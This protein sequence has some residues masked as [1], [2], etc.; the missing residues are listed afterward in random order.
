MDSK[1]NLT[2]KTFRQTRRMRMAGFAILL[3]CAIAA[4]VFGASALFAPNEKFIT[5]AA[6]DEAK[7]A[8]QTAVNNSLDSNGSEYTVTLGAEWGAVKSDNDSSFGTG[9]GF[10]S[11]GLYVPAGA[12]IVL[13][14][15]GYT[16]GRNLNV[17]TYKEPRTNGYVINVAGT[18]TIKDSSATGLG[19]IRDGGNTDSYSAGGV[20]VASTGVFNMQG[21]TIT[22]NNASKTNSAGGVYVA[23]GGKFHM[24]GGVISG[25]TAS[26]LNQT[27]GTDSTGGVYCAG[28]FTATGGSITGNAAGVGGIRI[29]GGTA[30]LSGLT[31]SANRSDASNY[32][33]KSGGGLYVSAEAQVTLENVK[34]TGNTTR[35]GHSGIY[36]AA[37][38]ELTV[39]NCEISGNQTDSILESIGALCVE[40]AA[41]VS[42]TR[43]FNNSAAIS[44][45]RVGGTLTL[46]DCE[47][48]GNSASSSNKNASQGL[49]TTTLA[50]SNLTLNN[51]VVSGNTTL[52]GSTFALNKGKLILN[53][54]EVKE[55]ITNY[56][57]YVPAAG[58]LS[59]GGKTYIYDNK[60]SADDTAAQ[61][62][63]YFVSS[64][65]KLGVVSALTTESK[66]GIYFNST[67]VL[68][69]G[70]GDY[71]PGDLSSV[72]VNE[73]SIA[74]DFEIRTIQFTEENGNKYDRREVFAQSHDS[75]SN[76]IYAVKQSL[77]NNT[78]ETCTLYSN[79]LTTS[80][81]FGSDATAFI[82]GSL[83]AP[84]GASVILD[85]NGFTIGYSKSST[86]NDCVI[87]VD[88]TLVIRDTSAAQTGKISG[89]YSYETSAALTGGVF[90]N[91]S[92]S[93]TLEG[94]TITGNKSMVKSTRGAGNV[95]VLGHFTMT[96]GVISGGIQQAYSGGVAYR[97][98]GAGGVLVAGGAVFEATGGTITG[99]VGSCID[100]AGGI[101]VERGGTCNLSGVTISN[102]TADSLNSGGA[103]VSYGALTITNCIISGNSEDN[104]SVSTDIAG[105]L[106]LYGGTAN[107]RDTQFTG[108]ASRVNTAA[109]RSRITAT[110]TN[111]T[112][113]GNYTNVATNNKNGKPAIWNTGNL[114]LLNCEIAGN[115]TNGTAKTFAPLY[116][117]AGA[118]VLENTN[119]K[120][121]TSYI[122]AVQIAGGTFTM[123][124]G[125]ISGNKS[126]DPVGI[127]YIAANLTAEFED[128]RIL[129]NTGTTVNGLQTAA[130]SNVTLTDCSITGGVLT[131]TGV[132]Y[133]VG[134]I[135]GTLTLENCELKNNG[136]GMYG[137]YVAA[138]GKLNIGGHTY[139]Y[140]NTNT[141]GEQKNVHIVSRSATIGVLSKLEGESK[142][143]VTKDATGPLTSGF[144][145]F[146]PGAEPEKYFFSDTYTASEITSVLVPDSEGIERVEA[147]TASHNPV[148]NWETAVQSSLDN[149]GATYTC[150]LY[151]DWVAPNSGRHNFGTTSPYYN[152]GALW[153]PA[154]AS[155]ILDLNGHAV[156]RTMGNSAQT[157]G[158]VIYVQGTLEIQ[159]NSES[160]GGKVKGGSNANNSWHAGGIHID[161]NG[162]L[163]LTSGSISENYNIAYQTGSAGV[164]VSNNAVFE[165]RGGSISNNTSIIYTSGHHG[166]GAVR[167]AAGGTF[168]MTGGTISNNSDRTSAAGQGG[169]IMVESGATANISNA[170]V[171]NNTAAGSGGS[172]AITS[173]GT[174]TIRDSVISGNQM[175]NQYAASLYL[176]GTAEIYDTEISGNRNTAGYGAIF[177]VGNTTLS[178]VTISGNTTGTSASTGHAPAVFV[179][180]GTFE[181]TGGKIINNTSTHTTRGAGA[182]WGNN[183]TIA[184]LTDVTISGNSAC[185][186]AVYAG[187]SA[188]VNLVGCE[189]S[190]NTSIGTGTP[191]GLVY[192]TAGQVNFEN[193]TITGNTS[194]KATLA[195]VNG[196]IAFKNSQIKNNTATAVSNVCYGAY[197][198]GTAVLTLDNSD[199]SENIAGYGIYL[200]DT[201]KI[202]M[203]GLV[204]ISGNKTAGNTNANVFFASGSAIFEI[205]EELSSGSQIYLSRNFNGVFTNN[206]GIYNTP[207]PLTYFFADDDTEIISLSVP[208]EGGA[209]VIEGATVSHDS[210]TNWEYAVTMSLANNGDTYTCK[211]YADWN[212]PLTGIYAF[213]TVA[214][215]YIN[216]ALY[217]P[218]GASVILDLNGHTI[219]RKQKRQQNGYVIYV[220]GT[221]VIRDNSE[222]QEG[223][224]TGGFD[225]YTYAGGVVVAAGGTVTLESG[226]IVGN[227]QAKGS[228]ASSFGGGVYVAGTFNM[229]GGSIRE[230]VLSGSSSK[231][232]GG[233]GVFVAKTGVFNMSD[234]VIAKNSVTSGWHGAGG[235]FAIA[236]SVVNITGGTITENTANQYGGGSIYASAVAT[237][238]VENCVISDNVNTLGGTSGMRI[239][240]K[241]G[242]FRNCTISG[243]N[244][245]AAVELGGAGF[246]FENVVFSNNYTGISLTASSG[247]IDAKFINTEIIG[248]QSNAI[249]CS[250]N[251]NTI[252]YEGG[253]ISGGAVILNT[254]TEVKLSDLTIENCTNINLG[255]SP[256]VT[257]Q[258]VTITGITGYIYMQE[259]AGVALLMEDCQVKNNN[260][261]SYGILFVKNGNSA[262]I[263]GGEFSENTAKYGAIYI[264]SEAT[265]VLDG[266]TM[267]GNTATGENAAGAISNYGELTID[268]CTVSKNKGVTAGGIYSATDL[269]LSSVVIDG[270]TSTA[271][272]GAG[273]VYC[274][275]TL[276]VTGGRI[277]ANKGVLAGGVYVPENANLELAGTAYINGNL[278]GSSRRSNVYFAN[279]LQKISI[280][281]PFVRGAQI[282]IVRAVAG[283]FTEGYGENNTKEP[284]QY[285]YADSPL[286]KVIT[287]GEGVGMEGSI[288]SYSNELN[289]STAVQAS[290]AEN[291][292]TKTVTLYADWVARASNSY[293]TEFG[294]TTGY[295]NGALYVPKGASIILDLKGY[296]VDR[297]LE[298]ARA[299]GY[300]I[301]VAGEFTLRDSGPIAPS[302][303]L[304]EGVE[305]STREM[306]ELTGGNNSTTN[307]G[308][309]MYIAANGKVKIENGNVYGN[310]A[311]GSNSAGGIY[312]AAVNGVLE[313]PSLEMIGGK[314]ENNV[315][316]TAGGIYTG[317]QSRIENAKVIG[318]RSSTIG[319]QGGIYVPSNVTLEMGGSVQV[320]DNQ[321]NTNIAGNLYL[322]GET[323]K[324]EVVSEFTSEAEIHLSRTQ[325]GVITHG[326]GTY[327]GEGEAERVFQTDNNATYFIRTEEVDGIIEVTVLSNDSIQNWS[328][329]V[330]TS[331]DNGGA[332]QNF[333]LYGD[334]TAS[335]N[336]TYVT[337]FGEDIGYSN[338]RLY[339]PAGASIVLD[340]KGYTINRN[341][342][343]AM[344]NG[345]V[346]YVAGTLRI[347][348]SVGGGKIT[349]GN[350]TGTGGIFIGNG[351]TLIVEGGTIT[352]NK[353]SS[354]SNAAG[355]NV[356]GTFEMTGG[357]IEGNVGS[358]IG[359]VYVETAGALKIGGNAVITG[360]TLSVDGTRSN[361]KLADLEGRIE[362]ISALTGGEKFSVLRENIGPFT[363]GYGERMTGLDP[364]D[365]FESESANYY[366]GTEGQNTL[367]EASMQT[368]NNM[369]NWS[370]AVKMSLAQ[371]GR[372]WTVTLTEDWTAEV[373][374]TYYTRSFGPDKLPG[375]Y[376]GAL[377]VPVGANIV[378][379]LNGYTVN[380]DL[381][382]NLT[383]EGRTN[384]YVINVSGKFILRDEPT[385]GR[386]ATG[387]MKGGYNSTKESGA[388]VYIA[389][390]GEFI[391]EGGTITDNRSV[392]E[393]SV[394]GVYVG[395]TFTV[396]NGTITQNTGKLAGGV[397]IPEATGEFNLG[398][399]TEIH[400]NLNGED[401]NKNVY[402]ES[403]SGIINVISTLENTTPIGVTRSGLG[404]FTHEYGRF[405]TVSPAVHFATENTLYD[406]EGRPIDGWQE[407][408]MTTKD[409]AMNWD[410]AVLTS[411]ARG[412]VQ[413][414][415]QM[416]VDWEAAANGSY[417]T[418]FGTRA[419]CYLDG[420]LYVPV[421][422]SVRMDL[423]SRT[424]N[425]N[426]Q[427]VRRNGYVII[428]AGTLVITDLTDNKEGKITGGMNNSGPGCLSVTGSGDVIFES[429]TM[430][431]NRGTNAGAV[432]TTGKF[433]LAGG[434]IEE[435]V[436]TNAGG[437]F[438]ENKAEALFTMA[439]GDIRNNRATSA[440]AVYTAGRF[441]M[442][443]DPASSTYGVISKNDGLSGGVYVAANGTFTLRSGEIKE[444]TGTSVGGVYVVN[445][446]TAN[447][448]MVGGTIGNN[449]GISAGGV[450]DAGYF[451]MSGGEIL[452]NRATGRT[453]TTGGG[454]GV[455]IPAT[456]TFRMVGGT[457]SGNVGLNGVRA[458]SSAILEMGGTA[459]VH[460]N[461][462]LDGLPCNVYLSI[463]TRMINIVSEFERGENGASIAV[464]R[465]S[466]GV[467]TSGYEDYNTMLPMNVFSSDNATEAVSVAYVEKEDG[468]RVMEAAIGTPVK[469]PARVENV[470]YNGKEQVVVTG[471]QTRYMQVVTPLQPGLTQ[472]QDNFTAINAGA[473]TITFVLNPGYCWD[474]GESGELS[475]RVN[476]MPREVE[477][478]WTG[479]EYVYDGE[480]H[481]PSAEAT[482]LLAG[483]VCQVTVT[484]S[485]IEAGKYTATAAVLSNENY[486]L[487]KTTKPDPSNPDQTILVFPTHEFEIRKAGITPELTTTD[488]VFGEDLKLEVSGNL[489]NGEVHYYLVDEETDEE[490]E[491][492]DGIFTPTGMS[493]VWVIARV[494]AT[495][496]TESGETVKTQ[497][498]IS[499]GNAP[500]Q[501]KNDTLTYG[502][503]GMLHLEI[504]TDYAGSEGIWYEFE[505]LEEGSGRLAETLGDNN[506]IGTKAGTAYILV[507]S[508][509]NEYYLA[510][511]MKLPVIVLPKPVELEWD[512]TKLTFVYDGMVHIPTAKVVN[513]GFDGDECA[514]TIGGGQTE[515]GKHLARGVILSNPNYTLEHSV[516]NSAEQEFEI[517]KAALRIDLI[518]TNATYGVNE[519]IEVKI[520]AS[521]FGKDNFGYD[522]TEIIGTEPLEFGLARIES[523]D[524]IDKLQESDYEAVE[525]Y[526]F[527]PPAAGLYVLRVRVNETANYQASTVDLNWEKDFL[528]IAK[529]EA[530]LELDKQEYEYGR[531]TKLTV[532]GTDPD[533]ELTFA[534]I[535]IAGNPGRARL[536]GDDDTILPTEIGKVRVQVEMKESANYLA[537][538]R[539]F[540]VDL[541][542]LPIEVTWVS[543]QE[544]TYNGQIQYPNYDFNR[545]GSDDVELIIMG[546]SN[547]G[548]GLT[549]T[550]VGLRGDRSKNYTLINNNPNG[551]NLST[552]YE[553]KP[554]PLS[555]TWLDTE[556]EYDGTPK[557]PTAVLEGLEINDV[558][559]AVLRGE[560]IEAGTYTAILDSITNPN[561]TIAHLTKEE[562]ETEYKIKKAQLFIGL[563]NATVDYGSTLQLE[564]L[565]RN[566]SNV[567]V[568]NVGT[569]TYELMPTASA[570]LDG[571]ILTPLVVNDTV[572]VRITVS[573]NQNIEGGTRE[574]YV[575]IRKGLAPITL[576]GEY[577][578]YGDL[579]TIEILNNVENGQV[580]SIT[581]EPTGDGGEAEQGG[582]IWELMPTH[583]GTVKVLITL[584]ET[585]HYR[586]DP[587]EIILEIK[588]RVVE[589]EWSGNSFVYNGQMQ[590][591]TVVGIN[592]LLAGDV[593]NI[594]QTSNLETNAGAYWMQALDL[595]N[596]NYTVIA[597]TDKAGNP[598][599]VQLEYVIQKAELP[600]PV[601]V[602]THTVY[603]TPLQLQVDGNLENGAIYYTVSDLTGS[604]TIMDDILTPT[605]AGTVSVRA[606]IAETQNYLACTVTGEVVIDQNTEPFELVEKETVYG[607]NLLLEL[608]GYNEG[609]K[610]QYEIEAGGTGD[611]TL[612]GNT[613]I[614]ILAG[615]VN[616]RI[617]VE[618]TNEYAGG[619]QVEVVTILPF[620]VELEWTLPETPFIYNGEV[621]VPTATVTNLFAGESCEVIV[622]GEK[623]AGAQLVATATGLS[624]PNYTLTGTMNLT[625]DYEI[626]PLLAIIEWEEPRVYPFTSFDI[627][628]KA[629]VVNKI[630]GDE[631]E[632]IVKGEQVDVGTDYEA[633]AYDLTNAN[634]TLDGAENLTTT[635]EI[636]MSHPN[637]ELTTVDAY[638]GTP[639][640][641]EISGNIGKG[642]LTYKIE[643]GGGP[644]DGEATIDE[645]GVLTATQT[646][647]VT[648][649]VY[650][651]E[652]SNTYAAETQ[653]TV[654]M[655]HKGKLPLL[656]TTTQTVYGTSADLEVSG[657][658]QSRPIRF[659]IESGGTGI[660]TI[661]ND[662]AWVDLA[663]E[664]VTL[665]ATQAGTVKIRVQIEETRN[666]EAY[667]EVYEFIVKPKPVELEWTLPD[668]VFV[669]NGTEQVPEAKIKNLE[670]GDDCY[671]I[672]SGSTDAG[673]DLTAAAA[674]IRNVADG[675]LNENYT[676]EGGINAE[677]QYEIA[678]RPI[679][680]EWGEPV[681]TFNG[682]EQTPTYTIKNLVGTDTTEVTISGAEVN[683]GYGY[684]AEI[685]GVENP[686]YTVEGGSG[687]SV[688]YS[689]EIAD[690]KIEITTTDAIYKQELQLEVSGNI[691]NGTVTYTIENLTGV[692]TIS[693][694]GKLYATKIGTV[695][696]TAYVAATS[697]TYAGM[698]E[699]TIITIEKAYSPIELLNDVVVYG[700]RVMLGVEN[701]MEYG[702]LTYRV[703]QN[704]YWDEDGNYH[705]IGGRGTVEPDGHFTATWVGQIRIFITVAET[706]SYK[707][708][709]IYKEI[710]I[711]QRKVELDWSGLEITYDGDYHRPQVWVTN[712]V[713]GDE[714][715]MQMW[716]SSVYRAAG[717]YHVTA[718][719]Y[720]GGGYSRQEN[721]TFEGVNKTNV[722]TIGK[723]PLTDITLK[724][725]ETTIDRDLKLELLNNYGKGEVTYEIVNDTGSGTINGDILHPETLGRVKVIIIVAESEN[726]AGATKE[727][728]VEI[729]KRYAP[730]TLTNRTTVYGTA[731]EILIGGTESGMTLAYDVQAG[732]G[733]ARMDGNR[734]IPTKAGTVSLFVTTNETENFQST[735]VEFIITIDPKAVAL[736][737]DAETLD[738]LYDG[739]YHAPTAKVTNTINGDECEVI[740]A[741]GQINAGTHTASGGT[742]SNANYTLAGATNATVEFTIRKNELTLEILTTEVTYGEDLTILLGGYYGNGKVTY[743]LENGTGS[744]T[745]NGNVFTPTNIGY[746]LITAEVAES[747]NYGSAKVTA[748]ITIKK[749]QR[750]LHGEITEV[751][752]GDKTLLELVNDDEQPEIRYEIQPGTGE[753]QIVDDVY[754]L[755]T[756][757]GTVTLTLTVEATPHYEAA[758]LSVTV[759]IKP[760]PVQLSWEN[761]DLTYNGAEQAPGAE[762]TNLAFETD[763]CTVTVRGERLAG[764]RQAEAIALSNPNYTLEGGEE[765]LHTYWIKQLIAELEWDESEFIYN[766]R[767]Q[768]PTARVVN[769]IGTDECTVLVMGSKNAGVDLVATAISLTNE[770]YTLEGAENITKLYDIAPLVAELEWGDTVLTYNGEMQVPELVIANA[771]PEDSYK[772]SVQGAER[773]V[774]KV[775]GREYY[776]AQVIDIDN[777]NY[778]LPEASDCTV[779]YT[780]VPL[781]IE[782]EWK[783]LTVE[784]TGEE[785]LP[786]YTITNVKDGDDLKF[787]ILGGGVNVGTYNIALTRAGADCDNYVIKSEDIGARYEIVAKE[788]T[789]VIRSRN[790]FAV[791]TG[792]E[793]K[794]PDN[795]YT[796][797]TD[798]LVGIDASS[799]L[800]D[801]FNV[802]TLVLTPRTLQ[803]GGIVRPIE[804]GEYTLV[805]TIVGGEITGNNNYHITLEISEEYGILTV[806]AAHS[807]ELAEGS[808]YQFITEV[809]EEIDGEYLYF[810]RTYAEL[811]WTH[812]IDDVDLERFVLGQI[813][814]DTT[815]NEFLKNLNQ[816]QLDMV[817]LFDNQ[818]NLI[819]NCGKPADGITEEELDD[820]EMYRIGTGYYVEFGPAGDPT[821]TVYLSVLGDVDGDGSLGAADNVQVLSYL[822]MV[823][824][825]DKLEYR[826]AAYIINGGTIGAEDAVEILSIIEGISTVDSHFFYPET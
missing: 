686:N 486:T 466:A 356:S 408:V 430:T 92:A 818:G 693:A 399:T 242:Y 495:N 596:E 568:T 585:D 520:T 156:N 663:T 561:Y 63:V 125:E 89:G 146:N 523:R 114:T 499:R 236:D 285:F 50:A 87:Y 152:S 245:G 718:S 574:E 181:M 290:L 445:N 137:L 635:F 264:G 613:F 522:I 282:G 231:A 169:A 654:V 676:V 246:T 142:I 351:G 667:D 346:I 751:I 74:T 176:S 75:A 612:F 154:G 433:K 696:V 309:G 460:G 501:L 171:S 609:R 413:E 66:I 55:N 17:G 578:V 161:P 548:T 730:L 441:V 660:A 472:R 480:P 562:T 220:A 189:L 742:L 436:G 731:L 743:T 447:F 364:K 126:L 249:S 750:E 479:D 641:L 98:G 183:G 668:P 385:D 642:A 665:T 450:Y 756:R 808:K 133:G 135:D 241:S 735:T 223:K 194:A 390:G 102:N 560:E 240:P 193:S 644:D 679:E 101:L 570:T 580:R 250:T 611:A 802:K 248:S 550:V 753:A 337:A 825:L 605:A 439:A 595:D 724:N 208:H 311:T 757:V 671:V 729:G 528:E 67:G 469:K 455:Y 119:I 771:V 432:Y 180:A 48:T 96:G 324:I 322:A 437:V 444:N 658:V 149:G 680:V 170:T 375:Y 25:N 497:I 518:T 15:N 789:V 716:V 489:G 32:A 257:M 410:Y 744:G 546:A 793:V 79:W 368:D 306:G 276:T 165:M 212:A 244:T 648:V 164:Y 598:I 701:N 205:L 529:G 545:F 121:N 775:T 295:L 563:K 53:G 49:I 178:N 398:G 42:N 737:W 7:A 434:V 782:F 712:V 633:I 31:V 16:L 19:I 71:N 69:E 414:E 341:L 755:P 230:N 594:T 107:I 468:S 378:L 423:N 826:L 424:L 84:A 524:D 259:S 604:A 14:L 221:L 697:N 382:T 549:A 371:S 634:Y 519:D 685:T 162:K 304:P 457:V 601:L 651:A 174:L 624:N 226:S 302:K 192:T 115:T 583:V 94:G 732:T 442:E 179:S 717:I 275:Q 592:N 281:G 699:P 318:N 354:G 215:C 123:T 721:Y 167:V 365:Y 810:R 725:H 153:V 21:G 237:L 669:Y 70:Y 531:A 691:G 9:V 804:K 452:N 659:T 81:A 217:V 727:E 58:N 484:G 739:L 4:I 540:E 779:N 792:E 425:R 30:D 347:I 132:S 317:S 12:N 491:L 328:H 418:A 625:Q 689:I 764:E 56:G 404:V 673:K 809:E 210:T 360:N 814:P 46:T 138:N 627:V 647:P 786:E 581:I 374:T 784:Y 262:T 415:F 677:T 357:R 628:P 405:N 615:T 711:A 741:G 284:T 745:L 130:G 822:E 232:T 117:T 353:S 467:F 569:I 417:T 637:V 362:V 555:V 83:L 77:A 426:L 358:G 774:N 435:N 80:T 661:T 638:Y 485:Q 500:L 487:K 116:S 683:A 261:N 366:I 234:G 47:I 35:Y 316:T 553:I 383:T 388:G 288:M 147:G 143:G 255:S 552:R 400:G 200:M 335:P 687:L 813:L 632:V 458:Y 537:R 279:D 93:L 320:K 715:V 498:Y 312:V 798:G 636:I 547:A 355:V 376:Y 692:A 326:Y 824:E 330:K 73:S 218:A 292:A 783:S 451:Q 124:G 344:A 794:I 384:G 462:S 421:G 770:N 280:I 28:T 394:G 438:V 34:I 253:K 440:G 51:T 530:P 551:G 155:V 422:A 490:T 590:G 514:V 797:T 704:S 805:P 694:D 781:E 273:G 591:P 380:R 348:D 614:P 297:N 690:V 411:L 766:G 287:E 470:V 769:L 10:M 24:S 505:L 45:I 36:V 334:W 780:I 104:S 145:K 381:L 321:T 2:G 785:V 359:G 188:S 129:D 379:N 131:G 720:R 536:E 538:T 582:S 238:N 401:V 670:P 820:Y 541:V 603:G 52:Y 492:P 815:I 811:G 597:D 298:G 610:I 817:R 589:I 420:A 65:S 332:T 213:G 584:S 78:T 619:T 128:V 327:N 622:S 796:L 160:G 517:T 618:A 350:S 268:A 599:Y 763:E 653:P 144:G 199:F 18:L 293:G 656:L 608:T 713:P 463:G 265:A 428:V 196:L 110:L 389:P 558:C 369:L 407:G 695:L 314:V 90:V 247:N 148:T 579:Y 26:A 266:V 621:Q 289:W 554:K 157:N 252:S 139:I 150:T 565:C 91:T 510:T 168:T 443:R 639:L 396:T 345:S 301:Y 588:P 278:E 698:S 409:N 790:V 682:E 709:T 464:T 516:N 819:Y 506:V 801:V 307:Q 788:I 323:A 197:V 707:E 723:A 277:S 315:G 349:G 214:N 211:L 544:L 666:Y 629:T 734:L 1:K 740:V 88:G 821:E 40:G 8:W 201:A 190:G 173:L 465:D 294:T 508:S 271:T 13:D 303:D 759:I 616:V 777:A 134:Y 352:G 251:V 243:H 254:K 703:D 768:V 27:N 393:N 566:K 799:K 474:T 678:P 473:Y 543:G 714:S 556:L 377:Y 557:I 37:K 120:N 532:S 816:S 195:L 617:T 800:E 203:Q 308:G 456:G 778:K 118:V 338:G 313:T 361:I 239:S 151:L 623:D 109:L 649:T 395:G 39:N 184:T 54:S 340:L 631:V 681:L 823:I 299:N 112:F 652:T 186:G 370:Y 22:N 575:T 749:I 534:I 105:G 227:Q 363:T 412:G 427:G 177:S 513:F 336:A 748:Q 453:K 325:I 752:Y 509:E 607:T 503:D 310:K 765:I 429:G 68:T 710:T 106:N 512:A 754:L 533:P 228:N 286:S 182:V 571:D 493:P 59:V 99:N 175:S 202:K 198:S 454:G 111:V 187:S 38:A 256:K 736:E 269:F 6:N 722:F 539:I 159:D 496:N 477:L 593:C 158:S 397:Y 20:Y 705:Y 43:I 305:P 233:A 209:Q 527:V 403:T 761:P 494:E 702:A 525:G 772:L 267:T 419:N 222:N 5:V 521:V 342:T 64:N 747:T 776:V 272:N 258:N 646:G 206:Y 733:D 76:W 172:G 515:A 655:I 482:N 586:A 329:A 787:A 576:R 339:V 738:F 812:G 762:V 481:V 606:N 300:V 507:R 706:E 650:V 100:S 387:K 95:R 795:W 291:G 726:Y 674:E 86:A 760:R 274:A 773:Y 319:G 807:I 260:N 664:Q 511:E 645:N 587:I 728:I 620:V 402:F 372:E 3:I 600:N 373:D 185:V 60:L 391:M 657:N 643:C 97:T 85:L 688:T 478:I 235:I 136:G 700:D 564:A 122:G 504:E 567:I 502:S 103:I 224:I 640:Q 57:I 72:F 803:N 108:N 191:F 572:T 163:I 343:S 626:K 204:H 476:L 127:I 461:E 791:Y 431:G 392:G 62:N 675:T 459:R 448:E 471:Y 219:D 333:M 23:E 44:I 416:Q 11:G 225:T 41:A 542:P 29:S 746:V 82:K 207:T 662:G 488:A 386:A 166:A 61:S 283:P 446:R 684:I 263:T 331:L 33:E 758:T 559:T 630:G 296:A 672:V 229:V 526:P 475:V 141:A 573:G 708:T 406:V 806:D 140:D 449:E 719:Y 113:S 216:G 483:D 577:A 535:A 602:T 367:Q 767:E 270:N